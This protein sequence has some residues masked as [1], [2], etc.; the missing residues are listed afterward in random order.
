MRASAVAAVMLLWAHGATAGQAAVDGLVFSDELGGFRITGATGSG[1][2]DDPF[3]VAEDVTGPGAAVLVIRGLTPDFG[4]RVGT[5]HPVGFALR[6]VITNR[7]RAAWS[8]LEIELQERLGVASDR[9]DGLSFG[10]GATAG[11]PFH[12]DRFATTI[13]TDEPVDSVTFEGGL[14]RPGETVTLE[15]VITDTSPLPAFF[16]VQR[17]ARPIARAEPEGRP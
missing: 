10:Q 16:L 14:L 17:L 8:Y 9:L 15:V 4:N 7:T 1:S 12:A 6:K 11:R 2:L 3:V 5:L 13:E